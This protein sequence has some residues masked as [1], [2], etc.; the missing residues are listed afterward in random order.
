MVEDWGDRMKLLKA[1]ADLLKSRPMFR[2][3]DLD[4]TELEGKTPVLNKNPELVEENEQGEN[5]QAIYV[6][7][8]RLNLT[9]IWARFKTL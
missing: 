7:P 8:N 6:R 2:K 5:P 3:I 9:T 1:E 4:G